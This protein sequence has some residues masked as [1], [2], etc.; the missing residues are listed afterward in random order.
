[1]RQTCESE[2]E[3]DGNNDAERERTSESE[4]EDLGAQ[5]DKACAS[6]LLDRAQ[7][8]MT[9]RTAATHLL[10]AVLWLATAVILLAMLLRMLPNNLDGKR[11]VPLIVALMPWLGILSLIIAITAI[12]VRAIG[13]RVLLATV[14]VVCVVVQ[15]GWHWGYIR[16]QQTISDAAST[17]VTQVSSDG[18]PNTSDRYARIMTFNTKE[19]HADAN[20]IVEIVKN[21]HV[22][23][24]ALQEVS[25]DLLNRLNSAGIANYL[26]YSVAAQQTWHDNGGVNVLYSA[27]PMENAKQNLIPVESS[28]VSAATIDFGGSKVRFGS[29]H[30]FSPRPRNQGLWNRSLDSLAQLQHYDNLYVLM[31]DFNSTWD[32]ASFRYLLGSRFLDSGQQAGEGLHMTYPAMMSIA[33]IDHI[34]HDKGVTVGNL[35]TAYIPGSDHRALLAT[36]EVC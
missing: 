21:E 30:P 15:I 6:R 18:L 25:W 7:H 29:V 4:I 11:Y 26:P 24:L 31:G 27:A 3:N 23:V 5:L 1:M 14:S 19:G 36:L 10:T 32:H 16:P 28:S 9:R 35:K 17:A 12:A 20:R 13:G 34:V 33:E 22:E 8:G 2:R